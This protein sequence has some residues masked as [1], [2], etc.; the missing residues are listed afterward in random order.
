MGDAEKK[1]VVP[2]IDTTSP[3]FLSSGDQPGNLITHVILNGN[4]YISWARAITFSLKAR[5]KFVF[6]DVS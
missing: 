5:R 3:Y 6:L 1:I 4:N 2:S